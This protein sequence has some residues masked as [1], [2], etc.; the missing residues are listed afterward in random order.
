[1]ASCELIVESLFPSMTFRSF[2]CSLGGVLVP[3]DPDRLVVLGDVRTREIRV[4][5]RWIVDEEVEGARIA[6][7]WRGL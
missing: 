4:V 3:G 7:L 2:P 1:M 6:R 5:P